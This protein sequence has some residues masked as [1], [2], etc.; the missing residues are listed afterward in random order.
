MPKIQSLIETCNECAHCKIFEQTG[1]KGGPYAA[2][3]VEFDLLLIVSVSSNPMNSIL[4]IP[5][6]C[7]LED[8]KS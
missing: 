7:E 5:N 1:N 8:H 3:C 2:I 6:N 4:N